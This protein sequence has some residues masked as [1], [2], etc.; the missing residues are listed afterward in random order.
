MKRNKEELKNHLNFDKAYKF[1]GLNRWDMFTHKKGAIV[2]RVIDAD[3]IQVLFDSGD[4]KTVRMYGIDTPES[5]RS[6]YMIEDHGIESTSY[7]KS[8]LTPGQKIKLES[9]GKGKYGRDL[10]IIEIGEGENLNELMVKHGIARTYDY[11]NEG[12]SF[13]DKLEKLEKEAEKMKKGIYKDG[14]GTKGS[15]M[16][17]ED[18]LNILYKINNYEG[19]VEDIDDYGIEEQKKIM[20]EVH[21]NKILK[22]IKTLS[23]Q[24]QKFEIDEVLSNEEKL[25]KEMKTEELKKLINSIDKD[26]LKYSYNEYKKE[27]LNLAYAQIKM[28]RNKKGSEEHYK[29]YM[30]KMN[31]TK[32][33]KND[34]MKVKNLAAK[35][36][37]EQEGET[38]FSHFK[39]E[40]P[41]YELARQIK[42][43]RRINKYKMASKEEIE[44]LKK[45]LVE[46][47]PGMKIEKLENVLNMTEKEFKK[48]Q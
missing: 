1:L 14:D 24:I 7:T 8:K 35:I 30:L 16:S 46:L 9:K 33:T 18:L 21:N 13:F 11:N 36:Y 22:E 47:H 23:N 25:L 10:A 45:L 6:G 5:K 34:F 20:A 32:A 31:G 26:N 15:K 41:T 29:E 38:I 42:G 4:L 44:E 37:L 12:G 17:D 43:L 39:K 40:M 27:L 3:T 48:I 19:R 28:V 2:V